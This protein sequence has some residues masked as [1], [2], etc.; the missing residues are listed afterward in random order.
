MLTLDQRKKRE[1]QDNWWGTQIKTNEK[2]HEL[3]IR[4]PPITDA[5]RLV[6]VRY[7]WKHGQFQTRS[8]ETTQHRRLLECRIDTLFD[9]LVAHHQA[10]LLIPRKQHDTL[11]RPRIQL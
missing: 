1:T 3:Q 5:V 6:L 9:L 7:K 11:V 8:P 4:Y 10:C 2:K